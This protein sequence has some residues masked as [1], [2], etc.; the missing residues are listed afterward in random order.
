MLTFFIYFGIACL[1]VFAFGCYVSYIVEKEKR[2][3]VF[4]EKMDRLREKW[5]RIDPFTNFVKNLFWWGAA[6]AFIYFI[7]LG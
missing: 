5:S 7:Y 1:G 2:D 4:A 6:A 3:P